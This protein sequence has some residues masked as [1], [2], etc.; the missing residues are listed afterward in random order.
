MGYTYVFLSEIM[1]A[2]MKVIP[3]RTID[4]SVFMSNKNSFVFVRQSLFN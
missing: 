4:M 3:Q 2:L 1:P